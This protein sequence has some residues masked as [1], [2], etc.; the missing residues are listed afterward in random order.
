MHLGT[1]TPLTLAIH[2]IAKRIIKSKCFECG[3]V[4]D[5]V[6]TG[7]LDFATDARPG[8]RSGFYLSNPMDAKENNV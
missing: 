3:V 6:L 2:N 4:S 7:T 1:L 5:S 8:Q